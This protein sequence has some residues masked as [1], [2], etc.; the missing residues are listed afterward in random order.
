MAT[1]L[2]VDDEAS[3]LKSLLF[4]LEQEGYQAHG[5]STGRESVARA[6]KLMPDVV[7]LDVNL[8]DMNGLEVLEVLRG[9]DPALPVI[10]VS[11]MSDTRL[12]VK[13]VKAGASDYVTKP[14]ELDELL[15]LIRTCLQRGRMSAE[16]E[17]HRR[18]S[19][20]QEGI[21]GESASIRQMN[22][23][24]ARIGASQGKR[25][26][27][28]GESGTGKALAARAIHA[29]SSRNGG[30][31]IEVN[32]A[33]LPEQLIEAELFG[34]EKGSYTGATHR[35]AGLVALA[36]TGTLFLD[37]IGELPLTLQAKL[38]H[39]LEDGHYRPVGAARQHQSD[40]RVVAAT[41]RDLAQQ[42]DAGT[43]RED[44]YYR[45]NV[46]RVTLPPLRDRSEDI[47]L[48]AEH[49]AQRFA[50]SEHSSPVRLSSEARACLV[51]HPWPGNVRELKNL[52]ESLTILLP[53][54]EIEVDDLP[55]QIAD[56]PGSAA[57]ADSSIARH[58]AAEEERI[59]RDALERAHGHRGRAADLLGISRH[60]LLRRLQRLGMQ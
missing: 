26:L 35:R 44:L 47:L 58:M 33:S 49:F 54:K 2:V 59:L 39:F 10:M 42:A 13:A 8:P 45:L 1:I 5:A 25:V 31:F 60:A 37:E 43:F 19:V 23:T 14:F 11:A 22:A 56:G 29:A 6:R 30:P 57:S 36:D 46:L 52:M 15:L 16:L 40:V 12:A 7:L 20:A 18:G 41:N 27:V 32:C 51:A 55:P 9:Q 34:A 3:V 48:L 50:M 17:F 21:V 24:L 28:L 38:L 53:G 4:A